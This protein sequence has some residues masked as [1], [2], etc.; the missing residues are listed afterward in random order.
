MSHTKLHIL[1]HSLGMPF[2]AETIKRASLGGSET[3]AY[4]K[5]RELAR[6]GHKVELWNNHQEDSVGDGVTFTWVGQASAEYPL[7]ERFERHARATPHDVLIIQRHPAAFHKKFAASV[8]IWE[9]HDLARHSANGSA[10]QNFWQANFITVVSEWHKRQVHE[11]WGVKKDAIRVVRNGV[12]PSLY[13]GLGL[14]TEVEV[15]R[16]ANTC[17]ELRAKGFVYPDDTFRLLYQSRPERGLEPLVMPGGIMDQLRDRK[18]IVLF[19]CGY[20]NTQPHVADYYAKLNH[21]ARVLPNVV[22][23]GHLTKPQLAMLQQMSSLLVYPT[24]FDEVSC[25]SA[26][27]AMHAG[28]PMLTCEAGALPETC[29]GAGVKLMRNKDE[30][31]NIKAFADEVRS[32]S[33]DSK[34]LQIMRDKQQDA[35]IQFTWESAVD[36]LEDNIFAEFSDYAP[37]R[38]VRHGF[39]HSDVQIANYGLDAVNPDNSE[40]HAAL[41]EAELYDFARTPDKYEA[42]YVK[43]QG[44]YYDGHEEQVIGEDVT[45]TTR[46]RATMLFMSKKQD[47]MMIS[48]NEP[49]PMRMLDYGCAHGHYLIPF[50]KILP[51]SKFFGVDIS[52][53]AIGAAIKWVQKEELGNVTLAFGGLEQVEQFAV[54]TLEELGDIEEITDGNNVVMKIPVMEPVDNR[55]DVIIAGEVLE[56]V[57]DPELLIRGLRAA[58][59]P[60]GWL[61][62]TTPAGRWEWSGTAAFREAREHLWHFS[63]HDLE[64]MLKD[65][66][67]EI[68]FAPAGH[69]RAGGVLGSY[70]WMLEEPMDSDAP[71]SPI[72]SLP[73]IEER[74]ATIVP[75]QTVTACIIVKDS[76]RTLRKCLE[77]FVDWI[78][79]IVIAIDPTT[80]DRTRLIVEQIQGDYPLKVIRMIDGLSATKDGFDAARNVTLDAAT[81]DWVLWLDADEE[82]QQPWELWKFLKNSCVSG[83]GLPQIHY[84]CNPAMVLTTDFPTRLF[85]KSCGA[86]FF[87]VVHEH[88]ETNMGEGVEYTVV[89]HDAQFLHSGYVDEE[90]RRQRYARNYPL[91]LRDIAKYPNRTLNLFLT[92][93]DLAQGVMFSLETSGGMPSEG[94]LVQARK[95]VS[96]FEEMLERKLHVRM[97][98]D[99]IEYYSM[100]LRL[101]GQGFEAETTLKFKKEPYN[102]LSVSTQVR[103]V[104]RTRAVYDKLITRI[105]EEAT[106]H[107]E[108]KHI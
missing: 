81:S 44:I 101:L 92:I 24:T 10:W 106:K 25:I 90:V 19:Y 100:M 39:E 105:S 99:A 15:D 91:L 12:D 30:G 65:F 80:K 6:R 13:S 2:N 93:R 34:R 54:S 88:P 42:H 3:A 17:Q 20:D 48:G 27:E 103:G 53:R 4:Y 41:S 14:A 87:G 35:A 85:R 40:M 37:R 38:L 11:V 76:E 26:M 73:L 60:G 52:K 71:D 29:K 72:V 84:S 74:L 82:L 107:Y 18:D 16:E 83:F 66:R 104:F 95:V 64:I 97:I 7:G 49:E 43:H 98:V 23:L 70:V 108:S 45:S 86:R 47:E 36:D 61:I 51:K 50:A 78:D 32:L 68:L 77:S 46:F 28:L 62:V 55:F 94:H 9:L 21:Y 96:M 59:K 79:E 22:N 5:A 89:R 69:D 75:R 31:L 56:H 57:P 58:L 63:R 67:H 8:C 1:I 102:D 33:R